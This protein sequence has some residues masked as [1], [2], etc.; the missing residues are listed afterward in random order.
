MAMSPLSVLP[1]MP[2]SSDRGRSQ[3][4]WSG[5]LPGQVESPTP[6]PDPPANRGCAERAELLGGYVSCQG[7]SALRQG[8]R[9]KSKD[10]QGPVYRFVPGGRRNRRASPGRSPRS[11]NRGGRSRLGAASLTRWRGGALVHGSSRDCQE[12]TSKGSDASCDGQV[13]HFVDQ[14]TAAEVS[15]VIA[16]CMTSE[17]PRVL[18]Q[19]SV[20]ILR[21]C[22]FELESTVPEET[23][24]RSVLIR[25][26]L[27]ATDSRREICA[28]QAAMA[29][30]GLRGL[31]WPV[32]SMLR[33]AGQSRSQESLTA[34]LETQQPPA[35]KGPVE[36]VESS[37]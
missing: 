21:G 15:R 5:I 26:M 6:S 30:R 19:A 36:V 18:S 9:S 4:T 29:P 1:G 17:R 37:S 2:E 28:A 13:E 7:W 20:A 3:D 33:T 22:L 31:R 12:Q 34:C 16:L 25:R 8:R 27:A 23:E 24:S 35:E 10:G 11:P 14:E 32:K